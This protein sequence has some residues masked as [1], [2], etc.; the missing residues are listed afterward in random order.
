MKGLIHIY[1]GDGKGKTTAAV[2]LVIRAVGQ[3]LKCCFISFHKNPEKYGYGEYKI[4]KKLNV[5]TYHFAK[6]CPY[7]DKKVNVGKVKKEVKNA[8]EF[9]KTKIFKQKF[10]IV[11][12]DEILVCVREKFL[13]VEELVD[14]LKSKPE[15]LE[16]ILTGQSSK[17]IVE[18]LSQKVDYITFMQKLKH[19]YDI[20]VIRR[21]G[22]EY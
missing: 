16:L 6:C 3:K 11:V 14:L 9:I 4:L 15:Q 20:G 19:P 8:V 13:E 22:I 5:K 12:L 18:V 2:G 7:F 10:N 1:T 17:E 21:K